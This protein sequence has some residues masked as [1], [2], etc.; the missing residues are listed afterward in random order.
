MGEVLKDEDNEYTDAEGEV[1]IAISVVPFFVLYCLERICQAIMKITNAIPT[2][3]YHPLLYRGVDESDAQCRISL[4]E[5]ELFRNVLHNL[6]L[7][8]CMG[9][10]VLG[11]FFTCEWLVDLATTLITR[12][13]N[14]SK[15]NYPTTLLLNKAEFTIKKTEM[16]VFFEDHLKKDH[17]WMFL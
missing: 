16:N 13:V 15:K 3:T 6:S 8:Q 1:N 11:D 10:A 12:K 7:V 2:Y 5:V 9:L 4:I 17:P 14:L